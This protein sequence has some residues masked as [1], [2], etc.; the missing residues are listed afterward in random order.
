[1]TDLSNIVDLETDEQIR[2]VKSNEGWYWK[3]ER[4]RK[5][6][7]QTQEK[8]EL[9]IFEKQ[10]MFEEDK[11]WKQRAFHRVFF[12]DRENNFATKFLS[13]LSCKTCIIPWSRSSSLWVAFECQECSSFLATKR[14]RWWRRFRGYDKGKVEKCV[15]VV[16]TRISW[17]S[18]ETWGTEEIQ[19]N[20]EG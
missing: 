14:N 13:S 12:S 2:S 8:S 5:R 10:K 3:S 20:S 9:K 11:T 15:F 4:E 6:M 19:V 16:L 1:M 7:K 17:E 18:R